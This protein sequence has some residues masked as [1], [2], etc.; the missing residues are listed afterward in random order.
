MPVL[1]REGEIFV[2]DLGAG[3]NR[4]NPE[5]VGGINRALDEVQRAAAPRALVLAAEG[6]VW[7]NGL[8]LEWF[9]QNPEKVAAF[10][11]EVHNLFARVLSFEVPTVAALQGHC[12][13]AGAMLAL[14]ADQRVMRA[15]RGYF[16][17]PE[18]DIRIPFT[19]GM[20][21]LIMARL[22]QPTAHIA[23]CTGRR[24]GGIEALAAGIVD[25]AV[26]ED[27]VRAAAIAR[28]RAQASKDSATLS[29]IKE[30]MYAPVLAILRGAPA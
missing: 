1:D 24:Y 6:K 29:T 22:S 16:C 27:Q 4:F 9:A 30:R 11:P 13:A 12:F 19:P 2:L 20:N 25:E 3:E 21:A 7:S 28:A 14:A 18:V 23:M 15:D 10:L 26:A 17:L 8:D 5:W